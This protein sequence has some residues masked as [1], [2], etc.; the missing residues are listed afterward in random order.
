MLAAYRFTTASVEPSVANT[1]LR[2]CG[3]WGGSPV[4][5]SPRRHVGSSGLRALP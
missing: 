1:E 2:P 4:N 5:S 3:S